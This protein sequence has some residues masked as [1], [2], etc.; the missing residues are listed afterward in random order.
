MRWERFWPE[1]SVAGPVNPGRP[2]KQRGRATA[3]AS[4]AVDGLAAA[5]PVSRVRSDQKNVAQDIHGDLL[6]P[7]RCCFASS[8][9]VRDLLDLRGR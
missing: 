6:A 5:S 3:I 1:L 4:G 2:P 9:E 7:L 8:V